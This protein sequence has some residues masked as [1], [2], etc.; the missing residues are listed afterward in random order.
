[1]T[2]GDNKF[3]SIDVNMKYKCNLLAN[4]P[5]DVEIFFKLLKY[6][7]K[8]EHLTEQN[9]TQTY[10]SYIK[11]YLV[12]MTVNYKIT[13]PVIGFFYEKIKFKNYDMFVKDD[14]NI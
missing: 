6:N 10:D 14:L 2:N 4:L 1:M 5:G 3:K 13:T 9:K 11:L 12:N 8:F 7:L